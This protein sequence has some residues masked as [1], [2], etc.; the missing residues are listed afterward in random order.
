MFKCSYIILV[1]YTLA[2]SCLQNI[3]TN[4]LCFVYVL[5]GTKLNFIQKFPGLKIL[6]SIFKRYIFSYEGIDIDI[7]IDLLLKFL[8]KWKLFVSLFDLF[9]Y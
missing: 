8:R 9:K 2:I 1:C 4:Q 3:L 6:T 7:D 5:Y